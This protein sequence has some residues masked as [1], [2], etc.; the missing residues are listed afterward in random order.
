MARDYEPLTDYLVVQMDPEVVLR[1]DQ[2]DAMVKGG[3]PPSA[4]KHAAWWAN[5][6]WSRP[7][8]RI[9]LDAGRNAHPDFQAGVVRFTFGGDNAFVKVIS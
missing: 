3:L 1:F 9:W 6:I 2:M 7:L 8:S 4:H 5:S